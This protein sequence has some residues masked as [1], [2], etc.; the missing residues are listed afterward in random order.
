[1]E[2]LAFHENV[3]T[4]SFQEHSETAVLLLSVQTLRKQKDGDTLSLLS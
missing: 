4:F 1:M 2:I 3:N